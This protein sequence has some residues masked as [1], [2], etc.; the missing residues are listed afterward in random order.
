[1][2]GVP[3][4]NPLNE[5]VL[6]KN[7]PKIH[8]YMHKFNGKLT[9]F[10]PPEISSGYV[11]CSNCYTIRI[12]LLCSVHCYILTM[13]LSEHACVCLFSVPLKTFEP[14]NAV[15]SNLPLLQLRIFF[16]STVLFLTS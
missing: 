10:K 13:K 12:W 4:S 9:K 1:M 14:F 3:G 8:K 15:M 2:E 5:S 7:S 11:P 16:S 6:V